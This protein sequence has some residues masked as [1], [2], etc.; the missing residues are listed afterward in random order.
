MSNSVLSSL[1]N[2]TLPNFDENDIAFYR[3]R[4]GE[5]SEESIFS[6]I[7]NTF[8]PP[9]NFQFP[10]VLKRQFQLSWL[11]NFSWLR[12]SK[13]A[14]GAF[15]LPCVVFGSRFP[16][17]S[18]KIQKLYSEP[19]CKWSDASRTFLR[20]E[21]T[22]NGLH[23]FCMP[24]FNSFIGERSGKFQPINVIVHRQFQEKVN[25]N[26]LVLRAIVD[27][28]IFCGRTNTPLRGHRDDSK[29]LPE[30]GA[31]SGCGTGRFNKL[32][33]FAVRNGNDVL[34]YH[35]D[36]CS[37]NASY[38]SKTSQNQLIKCCGKEVSETILL[39][40]KKRE[41]FSHHCR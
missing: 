33:N 2:E 22:K 10:K 37:K 13:S 35:L 9:E 23:E 12:Y 15:C 14:N 41:V 5:L 38:I 1:P 20:H 29:Y 3:D 17:K 21:T 19:F 36:S 28:V 31:Y 8:S 7:E 25:Q 34:A 26:R 18:Q 39:E 27:S 16:L 32:L 30:A 24:V 40:V 4:V 6:M 11:N